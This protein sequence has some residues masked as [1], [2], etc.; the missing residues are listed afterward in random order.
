MRSDSSSSVCQPKVAVPK[1]I[2]DTF[3][4]VDPSFLYSMTSPMVTT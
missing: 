4:P 1:Q 2:S 3:R